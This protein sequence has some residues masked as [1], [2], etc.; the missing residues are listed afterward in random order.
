MPTTPEATAKVV[1][2]DA[3]GSIAVTLQLPIVLSGLRVGSSGYLQADGSA[4]DGTTQS[5]NVLFG[6]G[7]A[8]NVCVAASTASATVS[9]LGMA[10]PAAPASGAIFAVTGPG[11][12][13]LEGNP[14][15]PGT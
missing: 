10:D 5:D 9:L 4:A 7:K 14:A 3:D 13:A 1:T 6:V 11:L 15:K 12:P 2:A 8:S